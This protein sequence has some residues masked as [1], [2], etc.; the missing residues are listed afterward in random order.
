MPWTSVRAEGAQVIRSEG[1]NHQVD[2]ATIPKGVIWVCAA[3][4]FYQPFTE[5]S[6]CWQ[7]QEV[8][9]RTQQTQQQEARWA[10]LSKVKVMTPPDS[11]GL[12][13]GECEAS[14]TPN[15]KVWSTQCA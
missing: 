10:I 4:M 14:Q 2:A 7:S 15:L 5:H 9:T 3:C 12:S 8:G 11:Q 13:G 1:H 6:M